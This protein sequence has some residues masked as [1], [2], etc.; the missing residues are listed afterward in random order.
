MTPDPAGALDEMPLDELLALLLR[1]FKRLLAARA[2]NLSDSELKALAQAVA[3]STLSI[4]ADS[5]RTALA[6]IIAESETVL[7]R[8]NLT[9]AESLATG[10]DAIPG[11]ETTAE[12]LEIADAKSNAELRIAAGAALAVMLSDLRCAPYLLDVIGHDAGAWDVDAVI[13]RRALL[14]AS[15]IDGGAD[16]W[17]E[18]VRA[19]L[20]ARRGRDGESH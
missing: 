8:W 18:Q 3:H 6:A 10:M 13:A 12:F 2:V 4:H 20:K 7:R 9:F 1:Q 14:F 15:G 11:W 5:V 16:D 17:L 19:W